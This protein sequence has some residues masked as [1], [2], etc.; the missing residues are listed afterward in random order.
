VHFYLP[1]EAVK[2]SHSCSYVGGSAHFAKAAGFDLVYREFTYPATA[3]DPSSN[4]MTVAPVIR[5]I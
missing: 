4:N 5:R 1:Q 3:Q 2:L